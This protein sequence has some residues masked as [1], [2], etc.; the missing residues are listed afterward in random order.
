MSAGD[1]RSARAP[2]RLPVAPLLVDLAGW[3]WR[4]L[5]LAV[6]AYLAL[7]AAI[8]LSLVSVPVAAALLLTALLSPAVA[9]QRR[10]GL[11]RWLATATTVLGALAVLAG[12][13][14]WVVNRAAV[15]APLLVR[16]LQGAVQRLPISNH[17][18]Q[19]ARTQVVDY[20]QSRGGSLTG[21]VITGVQTLGEVLSGVLLTLLLTIILLADG[22]R[23][24]HWLVARLPE[25]ARPHAIK[26]ARP[27]WGR[28]SAWIRGTVIIATFHGTVVGL[29]LL[30]LGAPLVAPLALLV[31][32]GSFIPLFG[33]LV[34]GGLAVLVTFATLGLTSALVLLGVLLLS[35]QF[36]AHVL[37]PFLVGRYVRL[38]PFVVAV[39]ITAGVLVAGLA[40]AL[41]AVPFTAAAHACLVHAKDSVNERRRWPRIPRVTPRRL[42][43]RPAPVT[44]NDNH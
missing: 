3:G 36:E 7:R 21:R 35:N 22:D 17:A 6:I 32:L 29:T 20:L 18:L 2:A 15:Q 12:G 27:A 23:M 8:Q 41:L 13:L 37:Q 38:H 19:Q 9:V 44:R 40:G 10:W 25:R 24:W 14:A 28:L 1:G 34:F 33:A 11:P 16:Q 26:A 31:F 42:G 5:L 4:L 30:L 43:G 39:V